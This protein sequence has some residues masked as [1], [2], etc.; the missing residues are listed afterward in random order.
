MLNGENVNVV[1]VVENPVVAGE[2]EVDCT[3]G[4]IT[5]GSVQVVATAAALYKSD[6]LAII[7]A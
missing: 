1:S 2:Y 5:S 3:V 6:Q 7:A 4:T